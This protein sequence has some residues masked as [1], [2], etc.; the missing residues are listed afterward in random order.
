[1]LSFDTLECV[2]VVRICDRKCEGVARE[3]FGTDC[4]GIVISSTKCES[5]SLLQG[6]EC[7]IF[8][9]G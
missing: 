7:R 5:F 8:S 6:M 2:Y 4:Q 1:M 9:S 3:G